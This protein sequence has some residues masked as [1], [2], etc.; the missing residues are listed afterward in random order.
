MRSTVAESES[1]GRSWDCIE[2]VEAERHR[3]GTRAQQAH[4]V[5]DVLEGALEDLGCE[6]LLTV[7]VWT[8][9]GLLTHHVLFVMSLAER[10]VHI[11]GI[12][13]Q[14]SEA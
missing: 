13:T 5:V 3:A 1:Q 8:S 11:A 14:P 7:E 10:V 6:R 4:D 2:R 9:R 12:T